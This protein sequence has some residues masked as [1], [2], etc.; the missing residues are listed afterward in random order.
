MIEFLATNPEAMLQEAV[1]RYEQSSGETLYPGDEHY[2]FLAQMVQLLVACREDINYVA[3]QNLLREASGA[4]LDEYGLQYDVP[5]LSAAHASV[6]LKFSVASPL[7]FSVTVPAGTRV[8]PDG[9]LLFST[10]ADVVIAVG[11]TDASGP[12]QAQQ[13]GAACNGFLPGQIRTM[14]DLVEYVTGAVNTEISSGGAD[15]E[16]DDAY[17][18]RIQLSW[19]AH[20]T[21]GDKDGYEYYAKTASPS[22]VDAEAVKTGDGE[23]TIYILTQDA[24][25]PSQELLDQVLASCS[26]KKRRPLTDHVLVQGAQEK[27]YSLSLTYFISRERA[28]EE[29]VIQTAVSTEINSF[30]AAQKKKLGGNLNPDDLRSALLRVGV[31]RID[32]TSPGFLELLPQEVAIAS[33]MTVIYGGLI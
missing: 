7:I 24:L 17:R 19:E 30:V 31:Y 23:V 29:A 12:A 27:E 32:F 5:R 15:T 11:E 20:S 16:N 22:V 10:L 8:T 18:Q 33:E 6:T 2:M 4:V 1:V 26:E 3:N 28:T 9:R 25:S 13:A 21:A 14:V